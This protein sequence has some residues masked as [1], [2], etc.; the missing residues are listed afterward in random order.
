MS[1][2]RSQYARWKS[3]VSILSRG[4]KV[5]AERLAMELD[6]SIRT[7]QR[8]LDALRDDYQA[9]IAFDTS[10]R[11]L[12]IEEIEWQLR[13]LRLTESELFHLVIAAGMAGQFRGTP[14]AAGLS[15]LFRKLETVLIEPIDLDPELIADRVSFHGGHPRPI[16]T[17][18][19]R[20][21]VG[22]LRNSQV[23]RIAYQAAGYPKP[24]TME[25]EPLHL[26]CRM[27]DWYLL[28]RREGF[29]DTRTYALSRVHKAEIMRRHFP[30]QPADA[31]DSA[32]KSFA[33]FVAKKGK[34]IRAKVRFTAES[35]EWIREREWHPEQV[36]T[37]HRDGG[38]TIALPIDGDKEALAWVLGWGAQAKVV[39]PK[40]LKE[41]VR[42]EVR[43]MAR[44]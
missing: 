17:E 38:L 20:T 14:I 33:R 28:A 41:R 9:P 43:A 24:T 23:L 4:G 10:K 15:N 27:G 25:V 37:E 42:E 26:A 12:F 5:T 7:I 22:G 34:T 18:I 3:I 32:Q 6:V 31:H 1:N 2:T 16:H 36:I 35:A 44:L 30:L 19:W 39:G 21:L 11:T 29:T 8:D 40:W 13:P